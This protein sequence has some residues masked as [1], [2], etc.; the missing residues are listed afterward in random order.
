VIG[1]RDDRA[2]RARV[3]QIEPRDAVG[4]AC[5]REHGQGIIEPFDAVGVD[6]QLRTSDGLEAEPRPYDHPG[7]AHTAYGRLEQPSIRAT[8]EL[9]HIPA[10]G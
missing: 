8:F 7:E 5:A 10:C 9:Q 1:A 3:K 6:G 2:P 4:P